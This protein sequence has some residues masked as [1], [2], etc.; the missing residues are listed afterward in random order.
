MRRIVLVSVWLVQHV[1]V[2]SDVGSEGDDCDA[3]SREQVA[4]HHSVGEDWVL[5]ECLALGPGIPVQWKLLCHLLD[6]D[7]SR[8]ADSE[9]GRTY[10]EQDLL[11][12]TELTEFKEGRT[13]A[14][15]RVNRRVTR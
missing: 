11:A 13:L 9:D 4:E 3:K 10:N 1:V 14:A 7:V 15:Q 5:A 2:D 8:D 6:K 12:L